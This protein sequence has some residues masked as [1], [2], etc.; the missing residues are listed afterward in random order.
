[1]SAKPKWVHGSLGDLI[2]IDNPAMDDH[3]RVGLIIEELSDYRYRILLPGKQIMTKMK[4]VRKL[5]RQNSQKLLDK[6]N[7][8]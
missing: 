1:M 6:R 2:Y 7:N 3:L 4:W 5:N 8:Q